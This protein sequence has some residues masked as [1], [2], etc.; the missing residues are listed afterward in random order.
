MKQVRS[1]VLREKRDVFLSIMFGFLAGMG[2]V[3]LFAN[4]GYLISKAAIT[5][6][7][8]ILTITIALLKFFSFTRALSRYGERL[9]SHRA[10]FTMLSNIRTHF[11][12]KLEPMAP[13]ISQRF[14]SGDLLSR[15][16]GDVESLQDY[17]LRVFYPPV[18]M[19]T[20]FTATIAVTVYFSPVTAGILAA[21]LLVTG[22]LIPSWYAIRQRKNAADVREARGKVSTEAAEFL[23]GFQDLKLHQRLG[24]KEEELLMQS[25]HYVSQQAEASR[26]RLASRTWNQTAAFAVSWLVLASGAALTAAGQLDG[27]FLAMLVM[28]SLT[29]FENAVPM[30]AYPS[31]AH[32]SRQAAGRLNEV[33]A[34]EASKIPEKEEMHPFPETAP[35][36]EFNNVTFTFPDEN[37]PALRDVSF[38]LPK[39]AATAVVGASGSGKSTLLQLL[40]GIYIPEAGEVKFNGLSTG[41]LDEKDIWKHT[42]AVLQDQHF[43]YGT[44]RENLQL[45]DE[46][47]SDEKLEK[48][49]ERVELPYLSLDLELREKASDL[50]GGEKQRLGLS[51]ALLRDTQVWLL[52]EPTSSVDAS[53][54]QH[55][56][57][58]IYQSASRKTL[59]HVSHRLQ[60]LEDMDQILVMED[61]KLAE[62]GTYSELMK[63]R[64]VFY[65]M[66]QTEAELFMTG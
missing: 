15:I 22:W 64:G 39:G 44:V 46:T 55:V 38:H 47:A 40:L 66:K 26:R 10:T 20:V 48:V 59:L 62:Q 16:V 49:L 27:V 35:E 13:R 34:D 50:S 21:G 18:V 5:P 17:F 58:E 53:T 3:A 11:F 32:E 33:M 52:D 65:K 30:A 60:G 41:R 31:Y 6:A 12:K 9:Y 42:N 19:L 45:A 29:V 28:I 36:I 24:H 4:S 7:L 63:K 8:S 51:R 14:R 25:K 56:L 23:Y 43:F 37:R 57:E 61:G 54:E 2:A 1:L